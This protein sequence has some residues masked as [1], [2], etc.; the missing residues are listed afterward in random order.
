MDDFEQYTWISN[1]KAKSGHK[2][3]DAVY[4]EFEALSSR[5]RVATVVPLSRSLCE[6]YPDYKLTVTNTGQ[7]DLSGYAKVGKATFDPDEKT[8]LTTR[9]YVPPITK[10]NGAE[11]TLGADV[12]FAK[13]T[14]YW[15]THQF[16][17]YLSEGIKDGTAGV[18]HYTFILH[19]SIESD[20]S[21]GSPIADK[22]VLAASKWTLELHNEIW[23][24]DQ[25]SW[26]KS[27]ELWRSAQESSWDDVILDEDMKTDLREDFEGFFDDKEEYTK[28]GIP[29]K[30]DAPFSFMAVSI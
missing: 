26:Q 30:V 27:S 11:G 4:G 28:Y 19:K 23:L 29:W 8:G 25:L 1:E 22:L 24:F 15:Q 21:G 9:V 10:L 3:G 20:T 18:Q 7:C 6:H 2:H 5:S 12:L 14:Y 16:I 17:V 13:M